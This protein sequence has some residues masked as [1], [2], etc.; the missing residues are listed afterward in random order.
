ML[1]SPTDFF[2]IICIMNRTFIPEGYNQLLGLKQTEKAIKIIK[3]YFQLGLSTELRLRRVT[4][5]L[6][7][8]K[9]D[10][11]NDDLNGIEKPVS[12]SIKNMNGKVAEVVQS[13]AKWKRMMLA[14]YDI[15]EGYGIYADMNAIRCDE[16]LDNIHSLYVDQWDWEKVI[17]SHQRNYEY[18]TVA[19]KKIYGVIKKTEFILFENYPDLEPLLP[20]EIKFIHSEELLSQFPGLDPAEREKEICRKYGAVFITGIGNILRNG[21]A[22]DGRAPDY[23]DWISPGYKGLP[24]LNGDIL[25]WNPVLKDSLELSSMG[26]RVSPE[27]LKKQLKLQKKEKRENLLFHRRLIKGELPLSIGGGIGQSR[28]CMLLL[29]KA[30]IGECQASIWPDEVL[31]EYAD[32]NIFFM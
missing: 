10:G 17:N 19:V 2:N 13:L 30:H 32:R 11:L 20:E 7:L 6:F 4:A 26:I 23:D 21:K 28:L 9:G 3:D 25:V 22:H 18:L 16:V 12:F 14:D 15:R 24:G 31:T 1:F 29:R 5:P 8:A 27:S